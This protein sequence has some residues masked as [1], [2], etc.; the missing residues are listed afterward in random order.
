MGVGTC[1]IV[2]ETLNSS[3]HLAVRCKRQTCCLNHEKLLMN[4]TPIGQRFVSFTFLVG[5]VS[6]H[7]GRLNRNLG[8]FDSTSNLILTVKMTSRS[9]LRGCVLYSWES[10][11]EG[12]CCFSPLETKS[13]KRVCFYKKAGIDFIS[14]RGINFLLRHSTFLEVSQSSHF[15]IFTFFFYMFKMVWMVILNQKSLEQAVMENTILI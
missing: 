3:S 1:S 5:M 9:F 14:D 4:L 12:C 2:D 11:A 10:Q 13:A 6:R 15:V 8:N 7:D